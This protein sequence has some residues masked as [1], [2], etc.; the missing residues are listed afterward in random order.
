[1]YKT[2]DSTT[3]ADAVLESDILDMEGAP[4]GMLFKILIQLTI[5]GKNDQPKT[6]N[7][8]IGSDIFFYGCRGG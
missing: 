7:T 8:L 4:M 5:F 2:R 3:N 6:K 1:M